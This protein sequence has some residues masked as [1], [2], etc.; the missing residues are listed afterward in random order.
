M[1]WLVMIVFR[2]FLAPC[3]MELIPQ[4]LLSQ[5]C[6]S[7]Q[8]NIEPT[9][10]HTTRIRN[11]N[12]K[13]PENSNFQRCDI[14]KVFESKSVRNLLFRIWCVYVSQV[15]RTRMKCVE[16]FSFRFRIAWKNFQFTNKLFINDKMNI[17]YL[18][19]TFHISRERK[20]EHAVRKR[21][22]RIEESSKT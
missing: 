10:T 19:C 6:R 2:I 22:E 3:M 15:K 9:H 14:G 21:N 8:M 4:L 5:T 20:R 18:H 11:P 1:I 7:T 13:T 12:L 17:K 16:W